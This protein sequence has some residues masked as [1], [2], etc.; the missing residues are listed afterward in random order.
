[1]AR[2]CGTC[3][4]CCTAMSVPELDKPNGVRCDHLTRDGRCGIYEDRPESCRIFRCTWLRGLG[5]YDTRP[6]NTGAVLHIEDGGHGEMGEA[7][8]LYTIDSRE[9]WRRSKY[10]R[11][12]INLF[13]KKGSGAIVVLG[14]S[15]KVIT[16]S[17]SRL[18]RL[19][20]KA[21]ITTRGVEDE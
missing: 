20:S 6:N 16:K 14:D 13:I 8:V 10:I 11:K 17:G 15:R 2:K 5:P 12:L 7:L 18:H 4:M 9:R 21:G 3:D 1:M 19:A